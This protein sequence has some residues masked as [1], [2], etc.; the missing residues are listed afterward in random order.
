M[1]WHLLVRGGQKFFD[2]KEMHAQLNQIFRAAVRS[3]AE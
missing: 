1:V 2:K 3:G